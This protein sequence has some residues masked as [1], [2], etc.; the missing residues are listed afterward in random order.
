MIQIGVYKIENSKN[1]KV[2]IGSSGNLYER[3]WVHFWQL[4][5]GFHPNQHLQAAYNKYGKEVFRF[6]VLETVSEDNLIKREQ[7]WMD[8]F[9]AQNRELYNT[10]LIAN[11]T[12]NIL[13]PESKMKI[14][15]TLKSKGIKPPSRKNIG[16]GYCKLY[17]PKGH[18]KTSKS[19]IHGSNACKECQRLKS[20][21]WRLNH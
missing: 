18:Y 10:T 8:S 21:Q 1:H 19:L 14:S 15:Q 17:C 6:D 11:R 13:S 12:V 16:Y 5:R 2:Y 20:H 3:Q 4:K 7:F 9:L